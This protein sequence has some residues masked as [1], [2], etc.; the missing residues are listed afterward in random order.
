MRY[1]MRIVAL[2]SLATTCH[3]QVPMDASLGGQ[4]F[5][6]NFGKQ[7]IDRKQG[8]YLYASGECD[9]AHRRITLSTDFR[10]VMLNEG[11]IYEG[12]SASEVELR[13]QEFLAGLKR[14]QIRASTDRGIRIGMRESEV[15]RILGKPTKT[16]WSKKF[17]ARELIYR[18]EIKYSKKKREEGNGTGVQ[19]SNYYLFRNG[20]LFY[21]ELSRDVVGGGC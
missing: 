12:L 15:L 1:V 6:K 17:Q 10:A 13:E 20:K 14:D 19:F 9:G 21:I 4:G 11:S 5:F 16:I 18:R 8:L 3:G 7:I 2:M